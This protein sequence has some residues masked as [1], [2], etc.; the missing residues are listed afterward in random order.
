MHEVNISPPLSLAG[1]FLNSETNLKSKIEKHN[2]SLLIFISDTSVARS[3]H[4]LRLEKKYFSY[5]R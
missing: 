1:F 2:I 3:L 4:L 5:I